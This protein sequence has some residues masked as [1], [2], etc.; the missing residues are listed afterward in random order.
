MAK[1]SFLAF[2]LLSV[3]AVPVFSAPRLEALVGFERAAILRDQAVQGGLLSEVQLRNPS[4]RLLPGHGELERFVGEAKADLGPAILVETLFL[5][6]KPHGRTEA[7]SEAERAGLF[8]RIIAL[9]TLTGIEYFSATR[10]AMRTFYESSQV[11]DNPRNRT[12]LP[13]PFF[14]TPPETLVLYARQRDLTFGD[15]TYRFEY[16]AGGDFVFFVQE[17]LT[18]M[19]AGIIPAIGRNSFR[20]VMAVIDTGDSLLI[21]AA[22]MARATALPGMGERIGNSFNNRLQAVLQWFSEH[23]DGVFVE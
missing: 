18:A 3:F 13:D 10:G 5:Y 11:I 17:N 16:R 14:A 23:A 2:M 15:N 21:Y 7:W 20:M 9:S 22:A 4:P 6:A 8:N 1:G 19:T 12:P